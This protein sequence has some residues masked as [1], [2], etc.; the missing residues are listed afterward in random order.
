MMTRKQQT[1]KGTME[2]VRECFEELGLANFKHE[3]ELVS[4]PQL[5]GVLDRF[6]RVGICEYRN[7]RK[8]LF[9][10]GKALK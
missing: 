8:L 3:V 1:G 4:K 2:M 7:F 9:G 6:L 5:M 10:S